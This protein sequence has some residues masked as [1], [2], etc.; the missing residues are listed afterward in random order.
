MVKD[1]P[2]FHV[3]HCLVVQW[4]DESDWTTDI[5]SSS[6]I[7]WHCPSGSGRILGEMKRKEEEEEEEGREGK[8]PLQGLSRSMLG[9]G[10]MT[11]STSC[12]SVQSQGQLKFREL[13]NRPF[14]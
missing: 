8:N 1:G 2:H 3:W 9:T 12:S 11:P 7:S 13:G 14:L 4:G 6:G 10:G 5:T